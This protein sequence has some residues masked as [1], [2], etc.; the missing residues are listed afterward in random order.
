[1]EWWSSVLRCQ[2]SSIRAAPHRRCEEARRRVQQ[3]CAEQ[4]NGS[5]LKRR[6][7]RGTGDAAKALGRVGV[8]GRSGWKARAVWTG[9]MGCMEQ[10]L[11]WQVPSAQNNKTDGTYGQHHKVRPGGR[12][13]AA[14]T[15]RQTL[16][17]RFGGPGRSWLIR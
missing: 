8:G 9:C 6:A 2:S 14:G 11:L 13:L 10:T 16:P 1:V 15:Q 5:P 17:K 4:K 12:R 7:S 3:L